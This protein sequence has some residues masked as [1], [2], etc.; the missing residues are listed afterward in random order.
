[1]IPLFAQIAPYILVVAVMAA[2][3]LIATHEE[4]RGNDRKS[5]HD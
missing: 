2:A 1:M 4:H 5:Q 3:L